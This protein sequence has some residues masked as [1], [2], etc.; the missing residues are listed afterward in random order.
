MNDENVICKEERKG[1]REEGK[2][3]KKLFCREVK[4]YVVCVM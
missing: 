1:R 3:R 4:W 2:K